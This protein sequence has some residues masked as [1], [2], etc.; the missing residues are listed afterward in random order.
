MA[1]PSLT[2]VT[3]SRLTDALADRIAATEPAD[4]AERIR[5]AVDGAPAA[6]P[7]RLADDLARALPARGR[8]VLRVRADGYLRPASLRFEYGRRDADAYYDLWVDDGA[9]WREVFG[10]LGAGGDGRVLP[11]LWDPSTDRATRAAYVTLPPGGVLLLDGPFLLGRGFPLDLGVHLHLS[12]GALARRTP[13]PDGWTL[14]AYERYARETAPE[15]TAD[16]L[17]RCDDPKRP[18]WTG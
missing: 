12:P 5:V 1:V 10:P 9:L 14:P 8:P 6:G 17:V 13:E 16:V 7:D 18:A 4:G 2:P 3:W 11:S 15:E